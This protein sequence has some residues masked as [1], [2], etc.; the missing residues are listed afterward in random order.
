MLE[1]FVLNKRATLKRP[2]AV[3][4]YELEPDMLKVLGLAAPEA[5][6]QISEPHI[7]AKWF[8][9]CGPRGPPLG[10]ALSARV[11]RNTSGGTLHL[12]CTAQTGWCSP[13][14]FVRASCWDPTM[15]DHWRG[16]DDWQPCG[17]FPCIRAN[18]DPEIIRPDRQI[19][20][21]HQRMG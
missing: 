10:P 14:L 1:D 11:L 13:C 20:D 3:L 18:P 17:P 5:Y 7:M 15:G 12:L 19:G 16:E 9:C 8:K 2:S 6:A 21:C 4:G